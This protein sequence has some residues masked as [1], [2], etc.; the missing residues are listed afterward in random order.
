MIIES[1]VSHW[2]SWSL[3]LEWC[4]GWIARGRM[5]FRWVCIAC[6]RI[7]GISPRDYNIGHAEL[8]ALICDRNARQ[9]LQ[10]RI[11]QVDASFTQSW[12]DSFL[13]VIA[14]LEN[15]NN[16]FL[17]LVNADP[18]IRFISTISMCVL[19]TQLASTPAGILC[20]HSS[21]SFL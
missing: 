19:T 11:I 5:I 8:F 13:I 21:M 20:S 1:I 14:Q 12:A 17:L 7:N 3:P 10:Q 6:L 18:N 4:S 2:F 16:F 9:C 15:Y